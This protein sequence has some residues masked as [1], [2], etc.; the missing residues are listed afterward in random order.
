MSTSIEEVILSLQFD[1][2]QFEKGVATSLKTFAELKK[3]MDFKVPNQNLKDFQKVIDKTDVSKIASPEKLSAIGRLNKAF[4]GTTEIV[5]KI[6]NLQQAVQR[7]SFK[8]PQDGLAELQGSANKFNMAQMGASIDQVSARFLAMSTIGITALSNIVNKAVDAGLNLGKALTIGPVGDGFNDYNTKLTSVQTVMNA[9]GK[10]IDEVSLRFDELDEY[11]DKTIYNLSDMTSAFAKFTNQAIDMDTAVPAIK[12]IANMVA[13]AGQDANAASSAMYNLTQSLG[14]GFL[15]TT[16]YKSLNLMNVA[17]QEFRDQ[18]TGAAVAAG[19]LSKNADG[20]FTILSDGSSKVVNAQQLFNDELSRG[21][22]NADILLK[23]LNDYGDTQTAIGKKAQAAAQDVKSLPMMIDTL[24]AAVGTSWTKTFELIFGDL[25]ESKELFTGMTNSIQGMLDAF[26]EARNAPLEEWKELGGREKLIEGLKDAVQGLLSV[27][28]PIKEAFM[29]VFPPATGKS[30]LTLTERF[31]E[32]AKK[33]TVSAET[34]DQIKRIFAGFFSVFKIVGTVIA[35]VIG[36]F[37][38]LGSGAATGEFG[39]LELLA[40]IGDAITRFAEFLAEGGKVKDFFN[41]L[42]TVISVPIQALSLLGQVI[43][44]IFQSEG[45]SNFFQGFMDALSGLGSSV[46]NAL[47]EID[48]NAGAAVISAGLLG[49]LVVGLKKF[50]LDNLNLDALTGGALSKI[51]ETFD[52]LTGALVALQTQVKGKTLLTIAGAVALLAASMVALSFVD[53]TKLGLALGAL[54]GAFAQL[55]IAMGIL[56]RIGGLKTI[57]VLPVISGAM[58]T[59]ATAVGILAAAMLILSTMDWEEIAKGLTATVG[60][61]ALL[62]GASIIL[63]KY[64]GG[65]LRAGIAMIPL[66]LG[67]GIL[68][69]ALKIMASMSWEEIGKGLATLAASLIIIAG[70]MKLMPLRLPFIAAGL[71][72]VGIAVNLIA[73]SLHTFASLSWKEM[74]KGLAGLAG[75]LVLIGI[76]VK[77]MPLTMPLIAAGLVLV[78]IAL[79]GISAFMKAMGT[80][81]WEEIG[82]GMAVLAGAFL[83]LSLGLNSMGATAILGSAALILAAIGITALVPAIAAMGKLSWKTIGKAF[84]VIA[85]GMIAIGLASVFLAPAVPVLLGIGAAMLIFGAGVALLGVGIAGIGVGIL[86]LVKAFQ[87]LADMSKEAFDLMIEQIP[88]FGIAIGEALTLFAVTLG[89]KGPILVEA[90]SRIITSMLQAL[91][92]NVPLMGEL[93]GLLI[94]TGLGVIETYYPA[95]VQTGITIALEF[96]KGIRDNI[97]EFVNV[98]TDIIINFIRGV[99]QAASRITDAAFGTAL[100]FLREMSASL[101]RN[102]PL[103]VDAAI[104]VG[105]AIGDG[106]IEGLKRKQPGFI[107]AATDTLGS[108]FSAATRFLGMGGPSKLFMEVGEEGMGGGLIRGLQNSESKVA[109]SAKHIGE[110]AVAKVREAMEQLI[111]EIPD[112]PN[113]QPV[114]TP[115]LDLSAM[116]TRASQLAAMLGVADL[117]YANDREN[118]T[119]IA[120]NEFARNEAE[121]EEGEG[122]GDTTYVFNQTNNSP[123]A[124]PRVEIYRQTNNLLSR[125]AKKK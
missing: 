109:E 19:T 105:L 97:G 55:L 29:Q 9:T 3:G 50:I 115:V 35:N 69:V 14:A 70:A 95:L 47:G 12:G 43:K 68:A 82:K 56:T 107:R 57:A 104:D 4:D 122:S 60:L 31:A 51:G 117:E 54:T 110:T 84:A 23:V 2:K 7:L 10:T 71:V 27:L 94:V 20:T 17:T 36:L 113:L 72:L 26:A 81:S 62:V 119:V 24:K 102:I 8:R 5:N 87:L 85:G 88:K 65:F 120:E 123:K 77:T 98:G 89:E 83:I 108:A 42:G 96:L 40:T 121:A 45:A 63:N 58:V 22:A 13:L 52:N 101:R 78:G 48:W 100:R 93:F 90:F 61:L 49:G 28:K 39:I 92:N 99:G 73:A 111:D 112:E 79:Q 53:S 76:A 41:I 106:F 15:T 18:L 11:A 67:I 124:L 25:E 125:G 37:V 118:A 44:D 66:A 80:M 38:G 75:A 103:I 86:A 6:G 30:L 16:D 91:I 114:I 32:F 33:M 46:Q 1:N 21:W 59:M 74:G 116:K 34:A 64:G